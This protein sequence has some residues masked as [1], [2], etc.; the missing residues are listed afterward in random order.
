MDQEIRACDVLVIGSGA[1][2]LSAAYTAARE[3]L[4]VVLI[5]S[6]DR[7]GGTT[8]YSGG[9]ALWYPANPVLRR[10]GTK[11]TVAD[12][13]RY[14]QAVVGARTPPELQETYVRGGSAVIAYLEQ[15]QNFQ[16]LPL[17][18]PD[19]F[20]ELPGA[21]TTNAR[22]IIPAPLNATDLGGWHEVLRNTLD[23]DRLGAPAP[24]LI[25]G[26]RALVAR[27][28]LALSAYDTASLLLN[29]ALVSLDTDAGSVTGAVVDHAGQQGVIRARRGVVLAA[30]GFEQHAS[31]RRRHGVPGAPKDSM[32]AP[33]NTGAA[34]RAAIAV[35]ASVDLMDQAWWAP[36]IVQ[37]D[38]GAVFTLDFP[39]GIFVNSSGTR[40][41][42]ES[43]PY[44]RAGR[45]LIEQLPEEDR[46]PRFWFVYDDR[47]GAMPPAGIPMVSLV[48]REAYERAG[49]WH[50]AD[51]IPALAELIGVPPPALSETVARFNQLVAAGADSDFQ[52]G[53]TVYDCFFHEGARPLTPITE[54]PFHAAAFGLSDLGT[55]GGLRTDASGRVLTEADGVIPGLYATGNTMAAPSGEAYPGGGNPIGTSLL[56][57]HLAALDLAGMPS[58]TQTP[59]P[60]TETVQAAVRRYLDAVSSGSGAS[61]AALYA[62][63]ATVEDPVGHPPVRGIADI[64]AFYA[65]LDAN[66]AVHAVL[67]DEVRVAGPRAVIPLTITLTRAGQQ[68]VIRP[69]NVMTL[70]REARITSMRSFYGAGN[71]TLPR[72]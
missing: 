56:F 11:D 33:T 43:A 39:A 22:Q 3:G 7:F 36:G 55:K 59:G 63:T 2:G 41:M 13:L 27:F 51:S 23:T 25:V 29:T 8:A 65:G 67:T 49:L 69:V 66:D 26:G 10:E 71:M 1:G 17:A 35:G 46:V 14:Y 48:A 9:G 72:D 24:E 32:G 47:A 6:A 70:D 31:M 58:D 54:G 15:D 50:T 57:G 68:T 19:Y 42:N 60:D 64:A 34:H 62:P 4:E 5:E 21:Q 40:F 53:A 16:F 45:I 12:A 61:I 52:R 18:W 20:E 28:L 38:G 44:D 30:G 37:P